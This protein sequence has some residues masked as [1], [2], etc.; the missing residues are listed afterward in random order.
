V[1]RGDPRR[2]SYPEVS[3]RAATFALVA[4]GLVALACLAAPGRGGAQSLQALPDIGDAYGVAF[5]QWAK[6]REPK[7]AILVIRRG[8][9]T[10]F[11]KGYGAD[12]A[13][14]TLI[15]SLS[16]A[17]TG[18]CMATLIRDG[19]LGFTTPLRDAMPQFF[20]Q[21]GAPVDSR[22][23]QVTVEELLVH[24]AGLRGNADDDSIYGV[25]AKRA[26]TGHGWVAAATPV[27]SEYLLKDR[28]ARHPGGRYSYSN[29]GY[30]ILTAIIEE[31]TGRPYEE[32]CREAVFGKLG[33]AMPMLHPDWRMLAGAGGWFI[34]GPDYLALLDVFDPSHPFLGDGVKAWI[35][36]AQKRWTPTNRDRWY[37]L[38]VNTW[39]GGGRWAVS[40]G[41]IL[42]A[43]GKNAR[44]EPI[45]GSIISHAFRAA[46][47]TA[48][49]IALDWASDAEISLNSLRKMIGE[50][51]KLVRMQ[52]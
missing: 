18:V 44:G 13:A 3:L 1:G 7:T 10:V 31:Q 29:T 45:E 11:A 43:R 22:L 50:T 19:K 52:P 47:G 25:F 17:I 23:Y 14:P 49:F 32:Y 41:G 42:H 24:R 26:S 46:D 9:K 30:E 35:D 21:F 38:G 12:P 51:H 5:N 27:L 37:G 33:I 6:N 34:P 2:G 15:A 48:V 20:K 16:K 36:Q 8:G 39:A 28:L 4:V 40:H